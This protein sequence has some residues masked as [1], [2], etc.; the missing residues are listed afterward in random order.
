MTK[1]KPPPEIDSLWRGLLNDRE[2]DEVRF[3]EI[4]T[5]EF[6]HGSPGHLHFTIIAKLAHFVDLTLQ[7][8]GHT[9]QDAM[10]KSARQERAEQIQGDQE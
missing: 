7:Q 9:L 6:C 5:R 4:Y 3:S 2:Q 10:G 1:K 8:Q